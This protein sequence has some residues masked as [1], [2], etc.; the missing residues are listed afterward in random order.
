M[1]GKSGDGGIDGNGILQLNPLV[2]IKVLFQCK[3]YAGPVPPAQIRDFR[4]ALR[5]RADK[6]III[7]TGTFTNDAKIEA[8]RDGAEPI[9]LIDIQRLIDLLEALEL[10]VRR[11][12]AYSIDEHFFDEFRE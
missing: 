4:G 12:T 9:E 5:G 1:T 2:S 3:R 8:T 7:T 11:V 10:G 6:G